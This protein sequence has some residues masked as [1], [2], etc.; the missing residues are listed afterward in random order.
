M[1][2]L[3]GDVYVQVLNQGMWKSSDKGATWSRVDGG[4][5]GGLAVMGP[6]IDIDQDNPSRLAVWSL[7]G[8]AAWTDGTAWR[9]MASQGRN[10]DFG[11]TDWATPAPQTMIAAKHEANG[12]V[13]L[14]TDGARSWK[15]LAITVV[16]SGS[17]PPPPFAMVG[18]MD[19]KTLIYG[20]GDGIYRSSD[21]GLTFQRV[22]DFNVQTRVPVLFKGVFYLGGANGL[23]RSAD[24]GASWQRQGSPL[25]MWLGPFFGSDENHIAAVTLSGIYLSNNAGA[26][27]SKAA[28]LPS[29]EVNFS[30]QIR[31]GYA[32]DPVNRRLYAGEVERSCMVLQLP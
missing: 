18:V 21:T 6:A 25:D 30:P 15:L 3:T 27:W 13:Y 31:A 4:T 8:N 29:T 2:R 28:D 26:S 24:K 12:E 11:A 17:W 7:D 20:N 23:I 10:W 5:V 16:A 1:N 32:W 9:T 19:A 14:S 22:A